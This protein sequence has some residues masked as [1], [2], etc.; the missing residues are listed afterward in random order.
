MRDDCIAVALGLPQLKVVDQ[1]ESEGHFE[2]TV[3]YRRGEATCPRC[4]EM[5]AREHDRRLRDKAVLLILIK[6]RFKCHCCGQDEE[7]AQGR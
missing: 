2:L 5:T 6:R 7:Q 1:S 3:A 4:G